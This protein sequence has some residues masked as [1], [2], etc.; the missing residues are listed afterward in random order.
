M[1]LMAGNLGLNYKYQANA[2]ETFDVYAND[3]D[4]NGKLDIV[5]GY[6]QD[7][8]QYPLRGKQCSSEQIPTIKYKY[9][10][11]D[12][13][14]EASLIDVYTEADLENSIHYKAHT[15]ASSYI[16]N[17]GDGKFKFHQLPDEAQIS[18]INGIVPYD[19]NE[20][21]NLDVVIAGNM[22]GSEI[23]T[24]RNDA[25]YGSLLLGDG[26]GVF[27]PLPID[28]SGI[29]I[30]GDTKGLDLLKTKDGISIIAANNSQQPTLLKLN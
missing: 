17:T 14:A 6:Y 29:F 30:K 20:D 2:S 23:E 15:F 4:K 28:E 12:L 1:D 3:Y 22:Y 16:E 13:F 27:T 26:K 8:V 21:G 24:P 11:Y 7:G 25:S 5:L 18:A 10:D 9:E 19:F